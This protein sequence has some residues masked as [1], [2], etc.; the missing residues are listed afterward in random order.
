MV[1]AAVLGYGTI[2]TGVVEVL[3]T[4]AHVVEK[5]AGTPIEVA[6]VL[7]L[8][9][10]PGSSIE[11]ILTHDYNDIA[12]DPSID[13]VVEVMGGVH[14][15]YEFVNAALL[16]G[17]NVV[18][19]NKALV[20]AYG[21]ELIKTA[22]EKNVNFFFEA[23][24]GG[25]IP[26]IRPLIECITADE[27]L[28][29]TGILN[30]TTNF[31]LTK[32]YNEGSA[33]DATLKEAQSLG[34]AEADPT[35]D[36]EG[37]DACR[38]IAILS[39][40]AYG[41]FVAFEDLSCTGITAISDV[42]VAYAKALEKKIKLLGTAVNKDGQT[43]AWVAPAMIG[44]D[45]PLYSVDDVM[46]AVSV[47]GNMLGEVMFYG[48]GAGMLPTASAVVSDIIVAAKNL[49]N[50]VPIKMDAEKLQM[51]ASD[52]IPQSWFVR[53]NASDSAAFSAAVPVKASITLPGLDEE[54]FITEEIA[55]A[56]LSEKTKGIGI[57]SRIMV[58]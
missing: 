55:L 49:H 27:I 36:I 15:A 1:K 53:V 40:L 34:Y 8:R 5:S 45:S 9:E 54:G 13:I 4:N 30:G 21:P 7:D 38:K 50:N 47:T 12:N 26:L 33:F 51:A 14:P 52:T 22:R 2:G 57:L 32:M 35:A 42:D 18:T 44:A 46:N 16:A 43:S 29:I 39:A 11:S 31:I 48:A 56:S 28:E 24:V 10:F 17:K 23:S 58:K 6:K 3:R 37:H 25:G 41:K 19:S 20:A